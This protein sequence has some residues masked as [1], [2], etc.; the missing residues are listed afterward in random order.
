MIRTA[1]LKAVG[2]IL[3]FFPAF[4]F[5][6]SVAAQS[7]EVGPAFS[8]V[9][10][11]KQGFTLMYEQRFAE[12]QTT[13]TGWASQHPDEPFGQVALA[14]SYLFE[15]F[16]RHQVLTSEFFLNDKRFLKGIEG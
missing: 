11:L 5:P 15:E 4:F 2:L 10:E 9:P 16:D 7:S 8:T 13:F 6:T 12:A 1:F 3:L 14:A